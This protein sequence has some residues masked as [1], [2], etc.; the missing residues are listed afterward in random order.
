MVSASIPSYM[1]VVYGCIESWGFEPIKKLTV[2][3]GRFRL[4]FGIG[5]APYHVRLMPS[6]T[7]YFH[8]QL[9]SGTVCVATVVLLL[10]FG[11]LLPPVVVTP[12]G[13]HESI[14][15]DSSQVDSPTNM[16]LNLHN[17]S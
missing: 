14:C 3:T 4:T 8:I 10:G 16:T 15:L 5:L 6:R 13:P 1:S 11:V 2:R 12:G 17:R 9:V 7:V